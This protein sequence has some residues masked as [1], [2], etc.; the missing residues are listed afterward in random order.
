MLQ[1]KRLTRR[2]KT[3]FNCAVPNDFGTAVWIFI[4]EVLVLIISWVATPANIIKIPKK[5][6]IVKTTPF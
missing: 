2:S 1:F 3:N 4:C 5:G 6:D